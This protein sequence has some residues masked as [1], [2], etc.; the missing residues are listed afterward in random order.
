MDGPQNTR[1]K[2]TRPNKSRPNKSR[3]DARPPPKSS[4]ALLGVGDAPPFTL[5]NSQGGGRVFLVCDHAGYAV[6]KALAGLGVKEEVFRD[7]MGHDIGA[8]NLTRGLSAR[9]DAPAVVGGYSRL[10]IDLNRELGH[11]GSIPGESH[12]V[13]IP[14]NRNLSVREA[15]RR[16]QALYH[17]YHD[18]ITALIDGFA[19]RGMVPAM[20]SIHSFTPELGEQSRP[21]Q[22]GVLW[23]RDPRIALPLIDQLHSH[24][25]LCVGDNQPYTGRM[26]NY[27]VDT[28]AQAAGLP[29]VAIE[30]RGDLIDTP[31]GVAEW[32]A[33]LE[34]ALR[35]ILAEDA[36]YR[37]E[38]F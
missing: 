23:I 30:V 19:A 11:E 12:G 1:P 17:P 14:G 4:P 36:L 22:V 7:H 9:L 15:R 26:F 33:R 21:W 28:K 29:H 3:K 13:A 25:G 34:R 18:A 38:M 5:V 35:P 2:N 20:L 6:P 8:E 27:T 24:P 31:Q 32:G 37:V 16:A 10:V